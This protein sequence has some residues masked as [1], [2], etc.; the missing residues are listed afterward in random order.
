MRTVFLLTIMAA[1]T[2]TTVSALAGPV[3]ADLTIIRSNSAFPNMENKYTLYCNPNG[4]TLPDAEQ[5]CKD[6]RSWL[7]HAENT[8]KKECTILGIVPWDRVDVAGRVD[9]REVNF[10]YQDCGEPYS[11]EIVPTGL[12]SK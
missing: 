10:S 1:I 9:G 3:Q 2:L 12:A 6:L 11:W 5:S 8:T 7:H 4:G